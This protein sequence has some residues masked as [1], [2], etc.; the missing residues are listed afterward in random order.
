MQY[1]AERPIMRRR[2]NRQ[3]G[4]RRQRRPQVMRR[5]TD[6]A[7]VRRY[8]I[9][10]SHGMLDRMHAGPDLGEVQQCDEK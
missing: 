3:G 9:L 6:F 2:C 7:D 8:T 5:Q 1:R 10:A 4:Q